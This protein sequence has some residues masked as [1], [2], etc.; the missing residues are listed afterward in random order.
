MRGDT[1]L[2]ERCLKGTVILLRWRRKRCSISSLCIFSAC[3][4]ASSSESF[5]ATSSRASK[6][7]MRSL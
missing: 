1:F 4:R 7:D 3:W 2:K 5:M 6:S